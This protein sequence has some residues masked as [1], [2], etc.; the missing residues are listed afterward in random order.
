MGHFE[1]LLRGEVRKFAVNARG[2][3]A[4]ALIFS[5]PNFRGMTQKSFPRRRIKS[6]SRHSANR[7][8]HPT[9]VAAR[10]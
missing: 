4:A 8:T 6:S 7:N 1:F 5:S 3:N 9:F 10:T 2:C